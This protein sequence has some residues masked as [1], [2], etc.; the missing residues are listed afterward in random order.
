MAGTLLRAGALEDALESNTQALQVYQDLT[1]RFPDNL[2]F[3]R[4]LAARYEAVADVLGDPDDL[5]LWRPAEALDYYRK[6]QAIAADLAGRDPYDAQAQRN[7]ATARLWVAKMLRESDPPAAAT[8]Y[9]QALAVNAGVYQLAPQNFQI[10]HELALSHRGLGI[11]LSGLRQPQEALAHLRQAVELQQANYTQHPARTWAHRALRRTY[12]VIGNILLKQG[13]LAGALENYRQA[14][15]VN[16]RLLEIH[17]NDLHLRRDRADGF[18][19]LGL[20]YDALAATRLPLPERA[21]ALR[22]A[23]AFH[24][25][26][27]QTWDEWLAAKLAVPYATRKREE[28][29]QHLSKSEAALARLKLNP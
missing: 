22:E 10:R 28:A 16:Q 25:R 7:L 6:S 5:N 3:R 12:A 20:Y 27:L 8:L 18:K 14:D 2:G 1:T 29:R 26:N 11:A 23:V 21:A 17:P 24:Q 9:R 15:A 4:M 19:N 13:E